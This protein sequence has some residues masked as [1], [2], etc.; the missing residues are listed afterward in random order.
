MYRGLLL[1]DLFERR[2]NFIQHLETVVNALLL[3]L[4]VSF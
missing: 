1:D 3:V 2:G 4:K